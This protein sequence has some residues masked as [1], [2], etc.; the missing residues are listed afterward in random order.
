[1]ISIKLVPTWVWVAAIVVAS[2]VSGTVAYWQGKDTVQDKW[3]LAKSK[4]DLEYERL[5]GQKDK[6][7]YITE[8]KY[9]DRVKTITE[10]GDTIVKYVDKYIPIGGGCTT[11]GM[12]TGAFRMLYDGAVTSTIPDPAQFA[13]AAPVSITDVAK[14][15]AENYKLCNIAYARVK[16]WEEWSAE[17]CKLNDKGCDN[18][19]Q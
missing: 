12:L 13:D 19:G 1:M 10:K 14:T 7:T 2:T 9:V 16:A 11:D 6:I 4:S 3:D 17:Q 15:S 18:G 5:K 8:V